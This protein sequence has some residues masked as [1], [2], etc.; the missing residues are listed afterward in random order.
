[1][2]ETLLKMKA[3]IED[4]KSRKARL[5]G[6]LDGIIGQLTNDYGYKTIGEAEKALEVLQKEIPLLEGDLEKEVTALKSAYAWKTI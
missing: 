1:M 3:E 6:E 2:E 5:E 4:N